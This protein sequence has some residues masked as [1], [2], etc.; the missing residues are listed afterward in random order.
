[1]DGIAP[2]GVKVLILPGGIL[3]ADRRVLYLA[4]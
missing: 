4:V 1:M 2:D 3:T